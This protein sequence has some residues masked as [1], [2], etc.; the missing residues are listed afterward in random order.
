MNQ[1]K[2]VTY[3]GAARRLRLFYIIR[4]CNY[5]IKTLC[6]DRHFRNR[7]PGTAVSPSRKCNIVVMISRERCSNS[8]T[9]APDQS[10]VG[11]VSSGT[12]TSKWTYTASAF[13]YSAFSFL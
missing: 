11:V 4:K 12:K 13:G 8:V 3:Q 2:R 9:P 10:W 6:V 5:D 7:F 1:K